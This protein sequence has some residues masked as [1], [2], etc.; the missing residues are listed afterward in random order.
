[1]SASVQQPYD[2]IAAFDLLLAG[3]QMMRPDWDSM[4]AAWQANNFQPLTQAQAIAA[5]TANHGGPPPAMLT[6]IPQLPTIDDAP[7]WM[8]DAGGT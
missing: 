4:Y 2:L 5:C 8:N 3:Y 1:M 6:S 7:T